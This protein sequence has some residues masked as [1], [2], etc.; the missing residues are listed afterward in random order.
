VFTSSSVQIPASS[1]VTSCAGGVGGFAEFAVGI[2]ASISSSSHSVGS[3]E[4]W[5][6][7]SQSR[8]IADPRFQIPSC[9]T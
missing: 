7:R 2:L 1:S 6:D 5:N 8:M 4:V 9:I 3:E